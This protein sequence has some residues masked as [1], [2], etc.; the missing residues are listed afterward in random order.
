M[1]SERICFPGSLDHGKYDKSL[2]SLL[3]IQ[4]LFL[5][6][7]FFFP[8]KLRRVILWEANAYGAWW[9]NGRAV[10]SFVWGSGTGLSL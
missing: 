6:I 7:S 1:S 8:R 10:S 5:F 4:A 3:E 2:S 9:C